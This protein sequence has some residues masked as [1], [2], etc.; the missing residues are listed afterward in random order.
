MLCLTW[1]VGNLEAGATIDV[2]LSYVT[3]LVSDGLDGTVKFVL[4]AAV[5]PQ[6]VSAVDVDAPVDEDVYGKPV[7]ANADVGYTFDADIHIETVSAITSV[8]C[9]SHSESVAVQV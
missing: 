9:P 6:L 1:A 7:G 8:V 3:E 5:A 2:R 4:P